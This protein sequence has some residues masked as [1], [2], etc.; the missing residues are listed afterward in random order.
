[1]QIAI[2]GTDKRL[3]DTKMSKSNDMITRCP[4]CATAF[5]A[6]QE[7]LNIAGGTVRCGSCLRVFDAKEHAL[8]PINTPEADV[9]AT[10]ADSP[11]AEPK[12]PKQKS[13]PTNDES[14]ALKL[15]E[16][17]NRETDRD[18]V[19]TENTDNKNLK[20]TTN[21]STNNDHS[22]RR[23]TKIEP[24]FHLIDEPKHSIDLSDTSLIDEHEHPAPDDLNNNEFD[25]GNELGDD[26]NIVDTEKLGS[27]D[28]SNLLLDKIELDSLEL[29]ETEDSGPFPWKSLLGACLMGALLLAQV[30][31]LRFDT[32]ST[33]PI[34]KPY[35]TAI[36]DTLGCTLPQQQNLQ[37]IQTT[38]LFVRSHPD[39]PNALL[40]DAIIINNAHFQQAYPA[41]RLSFLNIHGHV[42]ASRDFKP[43]E[44][45][46]GELIG[47]TI[48]PSNQPIQLSLAIVD[49][50]ESAVNYHIDVIAPKDAK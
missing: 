8:T 43:E 10:Q 30:A 26:P 6:T 36:C 35:Y 14:W 2:N 28:D 47:A 13:I 45:L 7:V 42:V 48:M 27:N 44:Y 37:Q 46:R 5:R 9:T 24:S 11:Q 1:M 50:G 12:P 3:P 23:N 18:S 4:Q 32:L 17:E 22:K 49:P 40:V 41:L 25:I 39:K 19:R 20:R 31:W 29:E 21:A 38:Q 33:R 15:L 16:E 34:Y